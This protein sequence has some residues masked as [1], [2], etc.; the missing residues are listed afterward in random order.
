VTR[1]AY[2]QHAAEEGPGALASWAARR[3]VALTAFRA[4]RG[5]LPD[6]SGF[7]GIVLLGG[8]FSATADQP[9]WLVAEREWLRSLI[10]GDRPIVAFCLG[11]Q[12][13]ATCLGARVSR[14][15]SEAG[16]ID[17]EILDAPAGAGS[18]LRVLSWHE[19]A[20]DLPAGAGMIARS[21][22]CPVQGFR[23]GERTV[24]L[25]FHPE[26]TAEIVAAMHQRFGDDMP[27]SLRARGDY[28]AMH[29]FLG[30]LLDRWLESF[31]ARSAR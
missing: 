20:F 12:L 30:S 23:L 3:G 29:A 27:D 13:V 10:A 7:D 14:G 11:A 18:A 19:D 2:V 8:P 17:V 22:R 24:A 9:A 1:I 25:Q 21:A 15:S 16:W 28:A 6:A 26:W 4:D 5:E 31:G